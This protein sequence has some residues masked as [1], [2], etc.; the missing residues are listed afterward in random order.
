MTLNIGVAGIVAPTAIGSHI[1]NDIKTIGASRFCTMYWAANNSP[2]VENTI[3]PVASCNCDTG[4]AYTY[5]IFAFLATAPAHSTSSSA[6]T[7]LSPV[8]PLV[9]M[10]RRRR[11]DADGLDLDHA[12]VGEPLH[13]PREDRRV[14]LEINQATRARNR[15]EIGRRLGQHQS[16]K[17]A[18]RKRSGA[19]Q[20]IARSASKPSK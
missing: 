11:I 14:R 5:R 8:W 16:E 4:G 17:F 10:A 6:S 15:R 19:R 12:R 13:H 1:L 18:Q 20:A 2:E 9:E 7:S 3:F